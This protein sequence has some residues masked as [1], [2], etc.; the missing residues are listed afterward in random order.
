MSRFDYIA[1][2][3]ISKDEQAEFKEA[4]TAVER[5]INLLLPANRESSLAIDR[6]EECYMWIGKAI[7]DKQIKKHSF[8]S[9][10]I[11]IAPFTLQEGKGY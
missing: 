5:L 3:E 9:D 8:P 2:D 6:L 4:V 11:E 1:Y 7:R 10:E